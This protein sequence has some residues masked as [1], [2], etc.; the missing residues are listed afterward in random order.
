ML[1]Q[2]RQRIK[3]NSAASDWKRRT[4]VTPSG[5][6]GGRAEPTGATR[7]PASSLEDPWPR[8]AA[9]PAGH[10]AASARTAGFLGTGSGK[11]ALCRHRVVRFS[12]TDWRRAE[13]FRGAFT[14]NGPA[15]VD[16]APK[17]GRANPVKTEKCP[18]WRDWVKLRAHWT[19]RRFRKSRTS[20]AADSR[21]R[22]RVTASLPGGPG[23]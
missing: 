5:A 8:D 6:D 17:P 18:E 10:E 3:K 4:C 15:I 23:I 22:F 7:G 11:A 12:K 13:E 14:P 9:I 16:C 19:P 2:S 1:S 20:R 21:R